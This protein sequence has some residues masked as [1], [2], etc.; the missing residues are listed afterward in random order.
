MGIDSAVKSNESET[1]NIYAAQAAEHKRLEDLTQA[2]RDAEAVAKQKRDSAKTTLENAI[3]AHG[4]A[5]D[6]K[7]DAEEAHTVAV[8]LLTT[9]QQDLARIKKLEEDGTT[10][11]DNQLESQL[12]SLLSHV[13]SGLS[14]LCNEVHL[15]QRIRLVV[16]EL[17][18]NYN[19]NNNN[20]YLQPCAQCISSKEDCTAANVKG[21]R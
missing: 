3:I 21:S 9:A 10:A 7:K 12:S 16:E 19:H 14:D 11:A 20:V 17:N 8:Q 6:T 18:V 5:S 15:I 1:N 13:K 2:A 4:D